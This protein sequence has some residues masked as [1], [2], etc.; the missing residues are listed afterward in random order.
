MGS[1][2]YQWW[3]NASNDNRKIL[4]PGWI[5]K[6]TGNTYYADKARRAQDAPYEGH[7]EIPV[8]QKDIV[9]HSFKLTDAGR[10]P[11]RII[12]AL[13]EDARIGGE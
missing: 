13:D 6:A 12:R 1:I 11:A 10:L 3:G 2:Q 7:K 5:A 9:L 4:K 8:R